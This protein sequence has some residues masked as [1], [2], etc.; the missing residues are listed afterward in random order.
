MGASK[1]L[2]TIQAINLQGDNGLIGAIDLWFF[3]GD[4]KN[5]NLCSV[6]TGGRP[7]GSDHP[8]AGSIT[9]DTPGVLIQAG[10]GR[11]V[12]RMG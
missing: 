8:K 3:D 1:T 6:N 12:G 10:E 2:G 4:I 7:A 5:T 9:I 11:A